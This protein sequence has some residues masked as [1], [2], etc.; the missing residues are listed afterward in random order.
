MPTESLQKPFEKTSACYVL[1][2]RFANAP[3][4]LYKFIMQLPETKTT[5]R[6]SETV[7]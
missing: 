2:I 3:N 7:L 1:E 4:N 6:N 5:N